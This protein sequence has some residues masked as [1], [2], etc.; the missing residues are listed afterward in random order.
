MIQWVHIIIW[1]EINV[2]SQTRSRNICLYYHLRVSI[3][4][5]LCILP[6]WIM[7]FSA[8]AF[9]SLDMNPFTINPYVSKF[10]RISHFY[11][12]DETQNLAGK[13]SLSQH[14]QMF[15]M[16]LIKHMLNNSRTESSQN[17]TL[18]GHIC[19]WFSVALQCEIRDISMKNNTHA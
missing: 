6:V 13:F 3:F 16:V 9:M 4:Q 10:L 8:I 18:R 1:S 7:S 2:C 11:F 19:F 15:I 12:E 17:L 5:T 14:C